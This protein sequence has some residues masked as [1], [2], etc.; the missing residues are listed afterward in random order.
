MGVVVMSFKNARFKPPR[1][2]DGDNHE[3]PLVRHCRVH[4]RCVDHSC[5]S[6]PATGETPKF[7]PKVF[8][9]ERS[10]STADNHFAHFR[11]QFVSVHRGGVLVFDQFGRAIEITQCQKEFEIWLAMATRNEGMRVGGRQ[12]SR[13]F[14]VGSPGSMVGLIGISKT[15]SRSIFQLGSRY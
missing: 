6:A 3:L 14:D 5:V 15:V 1:N 4:R 11:L 13:R 7:I 12:G 10:R 9:A 8:T 2:R